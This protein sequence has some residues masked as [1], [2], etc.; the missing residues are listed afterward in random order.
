MPAASLSL[1]FTA[2]LYQA[3]KNIPH[4]PQK[5]ILAYTEIPRVAKDLWEAL[6]SPNESLVLIP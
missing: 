3:L 5:S 2:M 1:H 6:L 4:P